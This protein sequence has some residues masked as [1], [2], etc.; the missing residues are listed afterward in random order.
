MTENK[1]DNYDIMSESCTEILTQIIHTAEKCS[2]TKIEVIA[3]MMTMI[4][5]ITRKGFALC[6]CVGMTR[7]QA[8]ARHIRNLRKHDLKENVDD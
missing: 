5:M 6:E 3:N 1:P 7:E 4:H 8:A 2:D